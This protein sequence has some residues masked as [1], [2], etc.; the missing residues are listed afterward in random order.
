ME[1][2]IFR[3]NRKEWKTRKE[4]FLTKKI[5]SVLLIICTFCLILS[6]TIFTTT[7]DSGKTDTKSLNGD[8]EFSIHANAEQIAKINSL[9]GKKMT[10]LEFYEEVFPDVAKHF[11]AHQRELFSKID[12]S[13][14]GTSE[15]LPPQ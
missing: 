14:P 8:Y 15:S 12:Y 1:E 4:I 7:K 6:S 11:S 13:Q 3:E 10:K 2:M 5:L 9:K